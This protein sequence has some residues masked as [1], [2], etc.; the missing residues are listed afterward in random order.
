[1]RTNLAI[2]GL[3]A[4][5]HALPALDKRGFSIGG[6]NSG[7]ICITDNCGD[8]NSGSG[9]VLTPGVHIRTAPD[10]DVKKL[11]EALVKLLGSKKPS[12]PVYMVAEQL[13]QLLL[14]EGFEF[15][16]QILGVWSSITVGK[17]QAGI[18]LPGSCSAEDIIGLQ[19]TLA[20]ILIIYGPNPPP[21]I[22]SLRNAVTA[23]LIF[24]KAAPDPDTGI[25][26]EIPDEGGEVVPDIP[27]G[28]GEVVP[29]VPSGGGSVVPDVPSGGGE[30]VPDVP[31]EGSIEIN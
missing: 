24:C 13:V 9:T 29:D 18:F 3:V 19:S 5:S 20:A 25:T 1:M 10:H 23:A 28:G 12:F 17:R 14:E 2:L 26:P 16:P 21:S 8:S 15:D 22:A 30:V 7:S 6:G 27:S 4:A 31:E 11:Y